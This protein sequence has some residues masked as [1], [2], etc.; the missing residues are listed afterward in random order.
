MGKVKT[1]RVKDRDI[2]VKTISF[3]SMMKILGT[4]ITPQG[5][6]SLCISDEDYLF[7]DSID[8]ESQEQINDANRLFEAIMEVN[9]GL[10]KI[11]P[12]EKKK[13]EEKEQNGNGNSGQAVT[14]DG[15]QT[16]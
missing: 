15:S 6:L 7:L 13:S 14:S 8:F 2:R 1:V 3:A 9:E 10:F 12:L 5:I 16:K 11:V 4:T